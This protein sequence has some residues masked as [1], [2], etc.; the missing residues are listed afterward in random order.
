[1]VFTVFVVHLLPQEKKLVNYLTWFDAMIQSILQVLLD[2][3]GN[4][5]RKNHRF[6]V[7]LDEKVVELP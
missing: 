4:F 2:K 1:M 3:I 6:Y 5:F 7:N